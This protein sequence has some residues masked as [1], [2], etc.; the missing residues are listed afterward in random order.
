MRQY[1]EVED[2]GNELNGLTIDNS[3]IPSSTTVTSWIQQ[4][5]DIIER[6]TGRIWGSVTFTDEY[7][8]YDGSGYLRLNN[9]PIISVTSL[10]YDNGNDVWNTLTEGRYNDFIIY[11]DEG[12]IKL[13]NNNVKAGFQQIKIT[14][15]AGYDPVNATVKNIVAKKTALRTIGTIINNQSSE[16][17]GSISVDVISISD[18]STFSLQRVTSLKDEINQM[19]NSLGR[20]KTFRYNRRW[21]N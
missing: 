20:F 5:S 2:V 21:L 3:S 16:E 14:Y 10:Q 4:E 8:D 13:L 7:L 18:P 19:I 11:K 6:E 9:A 1:C 17:G 15:I 12:E